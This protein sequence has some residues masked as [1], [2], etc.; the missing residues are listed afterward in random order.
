MWHILIT[1]TASVALHIKVSVYCWYPDITR[2][3]T[4]WVSLVTCVGQ[5]LFVIYFSNIHN[6]FLWTMEMLLKNIL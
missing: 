1:D 3:C 2:W 4:M 6:L 5:L